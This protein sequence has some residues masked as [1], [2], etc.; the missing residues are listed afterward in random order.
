MAFVV[1]VAQQKGGAGKSTVAANLAASLAGFGHRV[2]LLDT[3][4]QG[5]LARWH[6][7]RVKQGS[8]ANALTFEAPTGWRSTTVLDKLRNS[9]DFIV[10]DTPPHAETDTRI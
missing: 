1:V 2:G 3:D 7:E 10:V 9:H 6:T 8:R 4:P 5:T